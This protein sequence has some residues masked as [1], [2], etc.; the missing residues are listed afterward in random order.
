MT[1]A[2]TATRDYM[3]PEGCPLCSA[4]LSVRVTAAGPSGVC[5]HCG[6]L[7]RPL[8]TV[9]HQGLRVSYQGARA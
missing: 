5:K 9:T 7:G 8:I 6:W 3:I 1:E 2:L 4:D